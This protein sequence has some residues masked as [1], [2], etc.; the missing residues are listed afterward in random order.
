MKNSNKITI[1]ILEGS[2]EVFSCITEQIRRNK[3]SPQIII[4]TKIVMTGDEV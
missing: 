3:F 2:F 4:E 1:K